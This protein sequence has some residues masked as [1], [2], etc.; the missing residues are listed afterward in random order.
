[1]IPLPVYEELEGLAYRCDSIIYGV[2]GD[3]FHQGFTKQLAFDNDMKWLPDKPFQIK[4][5]SSFSI[6]SCSAS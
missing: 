3:G 1:M 6:N 5:A 2:F 4:C